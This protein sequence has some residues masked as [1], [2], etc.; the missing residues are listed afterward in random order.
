[1][2]FAETRERAVP[3]PRTGPGPGGPAT[4]SDRGDSTPAR[5][6]SGPVWWVAAIHAGGLLLLFIAM[7]TVAPRFEAMFLDFGAS[8]PWATQSVLGLARF[9][10]QGGFLL[11][12][13]VLAVAGAASWGLG[14]LADRLG[15][16]KLLAVWAVMGLLGLAGMG[17]GLAR[18]LMLPIATLV[19]ETGAAA[20]APG[21]VP[22][23]V[24]LDGLVLFILAV[25]AGLVLWGILRFAR[26]RAHPAPA[27][28]PRPGNGAGGGF[29]GSETPA[30]QGGEGPDATLWAPFQSP[31]VR[32]TAAHM[33]A[34]EKRDATRRAIFFGLWNAATFFVPVFL[35]MFSTLPAPMNGI[36]AGAVLALGLSF[37]PLLRRMQREFLCSTAWAREQGIRPEDLRRRRPEGHG[38]RS[39]WHRIAQQVLLA[40]AIAL[41]L[42][43]WVIR[44]FVIRNDALAPET[45]AGS[46]VLA[47]IP[48]SE[49]RPGDL[50]VYRD[51]DRY[52]AGRVS[53]ATP[54]GVQV[55]RNGVPD[56]AVARDAIRGRIVSV[57]WRGAATGPRVSVGGGRAVV[58]GDG[59]PGL[60]LVLRVGGREAWHC[61]FVNNAP[62]IAILQPSRRGG[63]LDVSVSGTD[64]A[65]LL[66]LSSIS[67][68]AGPGWL[69]IRGGEV[70]AAPDAPAVV[71]EFGR[72]DGS[73]EP[74][75]MGVEPER[76]PAAPLPPDGPAAAG[77]TNLEGRCGVA[78]AVAVTENATLAAALAA[79]RPVLD[80]LDPPPTVEFPP[81][82]PTSM[83]VF[84]RPQAFTVHDRYKSGQVGAAGRE[85][86]GPGFGGFVLRVHV[87]PRGEVH[88]AVTPQTIREPY[89]M[90]DLDVTPVGGTDRQLYWALAH[91]GATPTNVMADL[92]AALRGLES[93]R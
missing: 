47:W 32:E 90:T 82:T 38:P 21:P 46:Y 83:H 76:G 15:G 54:E 74:V 86:I 62:F 25:L 10:R 9:L 63:G 87:E 43:T 16:R 6:G 26:A 33:S 75:T 53:E 79:L 20:P 57:L 8:L 2:R 88:Q 70:R 66:T 48:A 35:L 81:D 30:A 42:R 93:A 31:R 52:F 34:D 92:R 3:P 60:R 69:A 41:V 49:F 67:V 5:R 59:A 56:F 55:N 4:A 36:Y 50:V 91:T 13:P 40:V 37:Y 45:P 51:G 68:G 73:R 85:T 72:D 58:R 44:P 84:H 12:P 61:G 39:R 80:R 19:A 1:M 65:P 23:R 18:V 71:G 28:F 27:G 24:P 17:V 29:Q 89:W 22:A 11:L 7:I 14:W 78:L 64:G 77:A